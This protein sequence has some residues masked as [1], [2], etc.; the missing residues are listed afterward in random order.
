MKMSYNGARFPTILEYDEQ[1]MLTQS[2]VDFRDLT[3]AGSGTQF[4]YENGRLSEMINSDISIA[5]L[6][7]TVNKLEYDGDARLKGIR[8][9]LIKGR[10]EILTR[11]E[12]GY[13]GNSVYFDSCKVYQTNQG[14]ETPYLLYTFT[15]DNEGNILTQS[16]WSPD[17]GI[18]LANHKDE[19]SYGDVDNPEYKLETPVSFIKYYSRKICTNVTRYNFDGTVL[20]QES[21]K[22]IK[23][24][25]ML[26]RVKSEK[27]TDLQYELR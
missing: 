7:Q 9:E 11:Y 10:P 4:K 27:G 5:G 3:D 6:A 8:E 12:F 2:Y 14:T 23:I 15:R 24:S 18:W 21:F 26:I 13:T 19:F 1:G 20:D 16:T 22:V 17:Q 25:P